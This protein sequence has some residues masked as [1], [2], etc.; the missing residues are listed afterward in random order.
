MTARAAT[1]SV[2]GGEQD[3][4]SLA[5]AVSAGEA[6]VEILK[7][8][9]RR[10]LV[11]TAGGPGGS[12][13]VKLWRW[14]GVRKRLRRAAGIDDAAREWRSL[15]RLERLGVRVPR[16]LA[17]CRLDATQ[18]GYSDAICMEDVGRCSSA[19]EHMKRLLAEGRMDEFARVESALIETA[20][21]MVRHG[22]VDIDCTLTNFVVAGEGELMRLDTEMTRW[23]GIASLFAGRYGEMIGR[24]TAS[25]AFCVQPRTDLAEAFARRLTEGL[26]PPKRVLARARRTV[27]AMLAHQLERR[28]IDTRLELSWACS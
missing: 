28:G 1:I 4:R 23:V 8:G 19:L 22:M 20:R 25:F 10:L 5:E 9:P 13:V 6:E 2:F 12:A 27:E 11:R 16:P 17:L 3:W 7:D 24:M 18:S 21:R 15:W 26:R 14:G